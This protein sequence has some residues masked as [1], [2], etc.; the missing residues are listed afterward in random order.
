M[1]PVPP[2][3]QVLITG[4]G[5]FPGAPTNPS[6]VLARS[7]ARSRRLGA[8]KVAAVTLPTQ[9][10]EAE[11][12]PARLNRE[13]PD[14]VLMIGLAARRKAL[15]VE[16]TGR[17]G[18]GRFPDVVRRRPASR[19]LTPGG[20]AQI[21]CAARPAALLHAMRGMGV[22]ARLSG[23]AGGYICNALTYRAYGWARDRGRLA[24]FVHVPRPRPGLTLAQMRRALEALL[25]ALLAEW[26]GRSIAAARR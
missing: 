19:V 18:S 8:A 22:P 10:R 12:F 4:F 20:P 14:I 24:V 7:L 5:P 26:R 23:N 21:A 13:A 1:P 11:E 9:W 2:L 25:R 15:C 16:I 6:S 17:N 3:S